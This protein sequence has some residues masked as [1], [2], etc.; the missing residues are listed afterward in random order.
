M[1][2]AFVLHRWPY[3][4][5]SLIVEV[6]SREQ[7]RFRVVAKGARRPKSQWRAILQ[8]FT[9]LLISARGRH[10][11]QTLTHAEATAE[12]FPLRGTGLYSG[13]Y[14]NELVQR[15]TSNYEPVEGLFEDYQQALRQ[16]ATSTQVEPA[17]R[18]F[19]W[20]LLCH[21]GHGF[22]WFHDE[23]GMAISAGGYYRFAAEQGFM[24][25][26][27]ERSGALI[28]ARIQQL[29]TFELSDPSLLNLM[30]I[31]MRQALRPYLGEQP[32]KSRQLF[33]QLSQL[34]QQTK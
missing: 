32:L 6:F 7:G 25:V 8:P 4:D 3:Q 17:L 31:I 33:T 29:A 18:E 22:D 19:E 20:R 30:K 15:L 10:E 14:L 12:S 2:P 26:E 11:L 1:E 13:F 34:S 21:L 5:S 9:P 28:G 24:R 27:Q 16:L 23:Q